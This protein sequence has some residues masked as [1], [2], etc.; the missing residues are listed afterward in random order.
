MPE[1][2]ASRKNNKNS[3]LP[4]PRTMGV[5][6]AIIAVMAFI[7]GTIRSEFSLVLIGAVIL[8]IF[9]YLYLAVLVLSIIHKKHITA[10]SAR[11]IPPQ[12]SAGQPVEIFFS[13]TALPEKGL[14][15]F[16]GVL[17]RY[18][19]NADTRDN[20]NLH[21]VFDLSGNSQRSSMEVQYRG[22]YFG[23]SD[24]VNIFD[25]LGFF[26]FSVY[27]SR[28]EDL[29]LAVTPPI[30]DEILNIPAR[31]GGNELREDPNFIRTDDLIDHRQ[32]VPG[33]DPR[34][35]NWKL[36][37]HVRELFV[38]EGEPEPPP[39]SRLVIL[40]DT[41]A[42]EMLYDPENGRA[43]VDILC[44][45]ALAI[46]LEN[47]NRGLDVLLGYNGGTLKSGKGPEL[48]SLLA[49]PYTQRFK[50][51]QPLPETTGSSAV[52]V[53]A[54]PRETAEPGSLD[55]F[56]KKRRPDQPVDLWFIYKDEKEGKAAELCSRMYSQRGGVYAR[57]IQAV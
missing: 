7:A 33:D 2:M 34:R 23:K 57:Y 49:F 45:Y 28:N 55:L 26:R 52:V 25:I 15:E 8:I 51:V 47:S 1:L 22:A 24:V 18:E 44:A 30:A 32:Y 42:D 4:V 14:M 48:A 39:K 17:I 50:D 38:R 36:Y 53:L 19:I 6:M 13:G 10:M 9:V 46:A 54:L 16:P 43:G 12:I 21:F 3:I 37:G 20:R 40:I 11:I 27:V 29:K 35:I 31:S 5:F 41:S 56:L